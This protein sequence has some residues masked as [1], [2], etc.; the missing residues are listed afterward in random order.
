MWQNWETNK[1]NRQPVSRMP[2]YR[3]LQRGVHSGTYRCPLK[4]SRAPV[5][6]ICFRENVGQHWPEVS[7]TLQD[8]DDNHNAEDSEPSARATA[9][10]LEHNVFHIIT[11]SYHLVRTIA[12]HLVVPHRACINGTNDLFL[13]VSSVFTRNIWRRIHT[14]LKIYIIFL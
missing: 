4:G 5:T 1:A 10:R 12:T 8:R 6:D 2:S 14:K 3:S 11:S 13:E 7:A 9:T